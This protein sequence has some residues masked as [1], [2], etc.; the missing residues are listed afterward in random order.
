[1]VSVVR[2]ASF[3]PRTATNGAPLTFLGDP[4]AAGASSHT[5]TDDGVL[6]APA[7]SWPW[8]PPIFIDLVGDDDK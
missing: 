2:A 5:N 3:L 4:R 1:M 6:V 8:A 7:L